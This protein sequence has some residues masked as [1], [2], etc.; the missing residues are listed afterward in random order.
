MKTHRFSGIAFD[1]H[2]QDVE[3]LVGRGVKSSLYGFGIFVGWG[4]VELENGHGGKRSRQCEEDWRRYEMI[5]AD[6]HHMTTYQMINV[7]DDDMI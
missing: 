7:D 6:E 3:V 2:Q 1:C 4:T 5:Q